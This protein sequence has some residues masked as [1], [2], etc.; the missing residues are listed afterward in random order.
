MAGRASGR[1]VARV[2]RGAE[3][4]TADS[5]HLLDALERA[6]AEPRRLRW[7]PWGVSPAWREAALALS[8]GEAAAR[9]RP[10]AGRPLALSHRGT[11]DI[12]RQDAFVRAIAGCEA[13]R[14]RCW[15]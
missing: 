11:R 10:P 1:L 14:P 12:Y 5:R 3:L 4:L 9:A 8:P 6:G 7:V 13:G 15:G 2:A